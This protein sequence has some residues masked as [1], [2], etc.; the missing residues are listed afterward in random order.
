LN[1][2]INDCNR[3]FHHPAEKTTAG[4]DPVQALFTAVSMETIA[5][6]QAGMRVQAM[7]N[8]L[9]NNLGGLALTV[10]GLWLGSMK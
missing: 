10:F 9:V 8:I 7:M 6:G 2:F 4:S 1:L 5:A 3:M